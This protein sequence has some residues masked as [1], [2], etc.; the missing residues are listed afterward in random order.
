MKILDIV[1]HRYGKLVAVSPQPGKKQRW[2]WQCDCGGRKTIVYYS[3]KA[4]LTRSCGCL[5]TEAIRKRPAKHGHRRGNKS[6]PT[7]QSY[8]NAK[9]R[10]TNPNSH[11]WNW[12]GGRGITMCERWIESFENFLADMGEAPK[13]YTLERCDNEIGYTPENCRWATKADQAKNK[14]GTIWVEYNG[15]RLCLKDYAK[16]I[17]RSYVYLFS[18]IRYHGAD[19]ISFVRKA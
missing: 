14:R 10:C 11:N 17:N 13:G 15:E 2:L 18:R 9:D 19:P 12:Y 1:G 16:A 7:L 6:T 3:V 4:G 8:A 5:R